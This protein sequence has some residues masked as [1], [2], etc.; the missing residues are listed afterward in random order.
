MITVIV[1]EVTYDK[2]AE[3]PAVVS[4]RIGMLSRVP[5]HFSQVPLVPMSKAVVGAMS[6]LA[7]GSTGSPR[8]QPRARHLVSVKG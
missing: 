8:I 5:C 2:D 1:G 7:V 6:F 3:R 4:S